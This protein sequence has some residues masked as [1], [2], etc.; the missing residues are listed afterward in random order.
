[1]KNNHNH[2]FT[3]FQIS[4]YLVDKDLPVTSYKSEEIDK[5]ENTLVTEKKH[6]SLKT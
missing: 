1:M 5:E 3:N 4:T 2:V 6:V